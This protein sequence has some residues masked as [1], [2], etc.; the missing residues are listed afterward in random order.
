MSNTKSKKT[1]SKTGLARCMELASDRKGLIFLSA[2]LSSLAAIAS[3]IPY[4][5]V[6][7]MI[8][9]I[10]NVFPDLVQLDMGRIMNYG[11]LAL[12]GIVANILLYFL[13]IFSSHIAAFGTLYDLKVLFADHITKIP[14]G[15]HLTIGS[16]R[17]RKIMDENIESVEGFIAHQFPDFVASITAPI[18]MVII[19]FVVD[20][21]FGLASLA[22]I[23]LAFIAEFIGFGSGAMKENMGKYQKASEEMNNASVEYVRGM[24]VV[25]AFNQTASSFKKL[26]EAISGYTEWVL[27][28]SLGWQNCMPAFTT[29]INNIYLILVPVGILIGSNTSNF[30]EFSMKFIFYLLFVPAIAGVLNKIM[31]ISESFMQIDGNVARMDEILNIP[32]MPETANPQKPQGED[33]VFDHVSFTYTGNN[34]EKAL[35]SVSFAAKQGQITAIVGPSG[36]GKSTIANL[37]SRFWDVTDGKITIGGVDL[38]DMAQNDLMR[39]VSFVFQDIFLFKQSILDNIRMGNRNATEEQVIAA[40]K[41]AQC[42]EFISKLPE[43]YHTVVG[44]KGVHLSGGERQRIAIARAIIKDSP[45]IVLDEAT[46]FSDP[47]NE[48][49]IQKAFEKLMQNKTVI[50]IAHRLS[51]IR[52]ADKIIVMEKGQIVESG[53]HDD[54]VAAGGRYFQMWNHYTEAINWKL[55]GKAV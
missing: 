44:T 40:A 12:A 25:K 19:L 27:K 29:I 24:S 52:N 26:Q 30:K 55:N 16:G 22:G 36:G 17:L 14:L 4:I 28:F 49:L 3:F 31:Y 33:V 10:L 18:V 41:A 9:E 35:E 42:H 15:Y 7:F 47:E 11:W 39:Q 1:K 43:G 48:Y 13:A 6:Y 20:W 2:L 45:I 54:L 32:E 51:T 38:R 21:R 34:E 5:A 46:A 37:I 50:I 8:R 23:I 53:K